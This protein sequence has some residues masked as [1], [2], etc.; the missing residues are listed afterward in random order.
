MIQTSTRQ[1]L[2]EALAG[3][4]EENRSV[5]LVPTMGFLHEGHLSLVDLARKK[6]DVV[7]VSIFV[8]PLQF[9]P[10]EDLEEYPRDL[11][12][13]L[14]LLR[15][16]GADLVFAPPV[17]EMYPF[18]E[19]EITVDP[20]PMGTILCGTYR[21]GHFNGVLTVVA[22]LFGI[23][24]PQ[25]GVFGQK[26]YQQA[27]LL[28]RMARDLEQGV[29]VIMGPVV[30]E[31]DGLAMSSRNVYLTPEERRDAAGIHRALLTLQGA[32]GEGESDPDELLRGLKAEI[33]GHP[34]LSVQYAELVHPETL[35]ALDRAVPGG[36]ALVAAHC[37]ET[38]LIDN[39][40]LIG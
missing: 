39:H 14:T 37:G 35:D 17:E 36:V 3:L 2:K 9:G 22:R 18:G 7:A 4:R 15:K 19:P 33:D 20:G 16:R 10:G 25:V 26:D 24:R 28:R 38:R 32:F 31:D 1:E 13:D 8:N 5:G 12:R 23:F 6:S 27:V 30:R 11:E 34:S 21:S 29:E 40:I